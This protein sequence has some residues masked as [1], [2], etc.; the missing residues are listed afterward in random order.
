MEELIR[1][2][3]S[4]LPKR[5]DSKEVPRYDM[6][7]HDQTLVSIVSDKEAT[8]S[9]VA[10]LCKR[11]R[12]PEKSVKDARM[13]LTADLFSS[14]LNSRFD[15]IAHRAAPPFLSAFAGNFQFT[16]GTNLYFTQAEVN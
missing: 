11:A 5:T 9:S 8:T 1:D 4:D 3:F 13:E 6:P 2:H 7:P 10:L 14:M 15:E 12:H 16:R